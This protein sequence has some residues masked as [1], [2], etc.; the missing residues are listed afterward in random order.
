MKCRSGAEEEDEEDEM[1]IC[2][3]DTEWRWWFWCCAGAAGWQAGKATSTCCSPCLLAF[4]VRILSYRAAVVSQI[5]SRNPFPHAA[6]HMCEDCTKSIPDATCHTNS[7]PRGGALQA[8]AVMGPDRRPNAAGNGRLRA[9]V[10]RAADIYQP[11][12][13]GKLIKMEARRP[14]AGG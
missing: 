1:W 13:G 8:R 2:V 4:H 7:A 14:A 9:T 11:S 12:H 5:R 10:V 3:G 6:C